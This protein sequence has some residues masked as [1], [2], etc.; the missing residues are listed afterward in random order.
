MQIGTRDQN[1]VVSQRSGQAL[2]ISTPALKCLDLTFFLSQLTSDPVTRIDHSVLS[3]IHTGS[4]ESFQLSLVSHDQLHRTILPTPFNSLRTFRRSLANFIAL[5][6]P[7][8]PSNLAKSGNFR[9]RRNFSVSLRQVKFFM[10]ATNTNGNFR[11]SWRKHK[12]RVL[13]A[14]IDHAS[15]N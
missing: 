15:S 5:K 10:R 6:L 3:R 4:F 7:G 11:G 8:G 9:S 14:S 12:L 13:C 1:V 2:V